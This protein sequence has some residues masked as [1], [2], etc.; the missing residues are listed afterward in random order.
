MVRV[1]DRGPFADTDRRIIDLSY[2]AAVLLEMVE[3]GVTEV[4]IEAVEPWQSRTSGF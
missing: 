4:R 1:N 3:A 2:G